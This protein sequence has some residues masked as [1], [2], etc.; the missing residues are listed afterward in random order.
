MSRYRQGIYINSL[1]YF[2]LTLGQINSAVNVVCVRFV[3]H[4]WGD[5]IGWF[6]VERGTATLWEREGDQSDGWR[7]GYF[8]IEKPAQVYRRT[9]KT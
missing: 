4:M 5:D 1:K 7:T 3:Y 6:V 9:S 8:E 2:R